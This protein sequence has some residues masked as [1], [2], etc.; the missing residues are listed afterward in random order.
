ML[1]VPPSTETPGIA[2]VPLVPLPAPPG[3]GYGEIPLRALESAPRPE[4][5][6]PAPEPSPESPLPGP[7]PRPMPF[8]PPL[9]PRPLFAVP[10]GDIAIAPPPFEF[11]K[12]TVDPGWLDTTTP[13]PE[14]FPLLP[15]GAIDEP[16][17]S[18]P[19]APLPLL[20][21]P[22]PVSAFPPPTPP[23]VGGGGTTEFA[24][25]PDPP[26]LFLLPPL[27]LLLA[28]FDAASLDAPFL[29]ILSAGGTACV[30][31]V[32]LPDLVCDPPA[33]ADGGGGTGCERRSPLRV[34]PQL[35]RSRLTCDGGGA[36]T[37]GAGK[38]SLVVG[39]ARSRCGAETGGATT[40]VVC[41]ICT[42]ELAKSRGVWLGAGATTVDAIEE[43]E[44]NLSVAIFGAG[45][46]GVGLTALAAR[47]LS[48]ASL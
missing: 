6:L 1:V 40:S 27:A 38:D 48:C 46:I 28:P 33:A 39:A 45:A 20:P 14:A 7:L 2:G 41:E 8:P 22:A 36:T 47:R 17:S 23:T 31:S 19:P 26:R 34:L 44:R 9:P 42:R 16:R 43:A 24:S 3:P 15:G 11:G 35:L 12:P 21:R 37:V 10:S 5:S 30:P 18:G 4:P 29:L 32:P 13:F 25:N